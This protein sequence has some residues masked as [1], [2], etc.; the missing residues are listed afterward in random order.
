MPRNEVRTHEITFCAKVAKWSEEIFRRHPE[1]P[2]ARVEIEE[3]TARDR[4]RS[5]L[6]VYDRKGNIPLCGEVKLPGTPEGR[7]PYAHGLIGDAFE[8][9]SN[10]GAPFFF[11]WNVN[12]LVLFDSKKWHLAID[13]RQMADYNLGLALERREDVDRPEVEAQIKVFLETFY[14]EF[15]A[16]LSGAKPDWA[17]PLGAFFLRAFESHLD[18]P[19]KL[20]AAYLHRKAESDKGFDARLQ[21]WMIRDQSWA[22]IRHDP[23]EWRRLLDRAART[24]CYVFA[25]RLLFYESVRAKF[26]ELAEL[27]IP[28]AGIETAM[29]AHFQRAFQEAVEVTGDYET[30]FYPYEAAEDWVGPL[31][32]AHQEAAEAWGAVL[33]N[34]VRFDLRN[35]RTDILG[36]IFKRL[37]AP[38]ERRR[39]GQ[40]YTNEDLVDVINAFCIR[41]ANDV[42]CDPACGSGSFLVRAYHRKAFLDPHRTHEE[43]LSEIYGVD[44]ALFAAH[45][46]TLNLASRNVQ[47]VENYPR[48]R[49]GNFFE[50]IKDIRDGRPFCALPRALREPDGHREKH[51]VPFAPLDAAIGNPP[52]VRQE[53]IPKHGQKGARPMQTKE[54][55]AALVADFWPRLELSGRSDLHCYFWPAVTWR[56]KEEGWFGF[57]VSSS[58]LDVEY[59][60]ALQEWILSNFKIHAIMESHAEPWFEDAR[61]KTCAVILQRCSDEKARRGHLVKF[62]RL[63][64][65][66]AQILGQRDGEAARQ[67]AAEKLRDT[68]IRQK[69]DRSRDEFRIIV[70]KQGDLWE[71][72]V[73]AGRLFELQKQRQLAGTSYDGQSGKPPLKVR[74]MMLDETNGENEDAETDENGNGVFHGISASGYGGGKWGKYLRAP[75]LYFRIMDRFR[76]R[77]VPL[78]EIATIRFGVKSGCDA[79]FMPRDVSASFLAKYDKH[80][81][82]T[83]PFHTGCRRDE[84]ESGKAKLVLAGDGTVHAI[85]AEYLV[86][87]VHSLMNVSRPIVRAQDLDRLILLVAKPTEK[88]K[89]TYV[90]RYLRYGERHTIVSKKSQAVP[91]SKRPTC[92][93]R[94]PWYDLTYTKRGHLVWSKSQHYRHVVVYNQHGL[95]VNCNLYDVTVEDE[96][97]RPPDVVA[98]VLNSTLVAWLKIYGGRY[99]G[100]E[101]NLKTEVVDVNMLQVPDPSS[102]EPGVA[103]A[104]REAFQRLC[105]RDTRGMVEEA[106]MACRDPKKARELAEQPLALPWELQQADRR[107]L[108]LAVFEMLG[109]SDVA[110]RERLC[111]ELYREVTAHFRQIRVV[112]IK[113]QEQRSQTNDRGFRTD[114]LA[115][116]LWDALPEEDRVPLTL[117]IA[118]NADN[119]LEVTIPDG[120]P[121]LPEASD[122]FG[123]NTVFFRQGKGKA[124]SQLALPSRAHAELVRLLASR[125]IRGSIALPTSAKDATSLLARVTD[126]LAALTEQA[127]QLAGR[128]TG[129]ERRA[130]DLADLLMQ[131]LIHGKPKREGEDEQESDPSASEED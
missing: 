122:M 44:I 124:T 30:I 13:D 83:A 62:V 53:K 50:V 112:E 68:I 84:V 46:A 82:R 113:K 40:F 5:D 118:R 89:G 86:P 97:R 111:D 58:W 107:A 96:K 105:Q 80:A 36:D 100:T 42:V 39:F 25:N 77:F 61:V 90:G 24:L 47:D 120:T 110:E 128:R 56:L 101:G 98:A 54:D 12:I 64:V 71:D 8:K 131:W 33:Q 66:L 35:I 6:R 52:Y 91:V 11:T 55:I 81:W 108:D 41:R 74:E 15:A 65:P 31:V 125:N 70:K 63:N 67:A 7:N 16:I 57:L 79:F 94:E 115:A 49:R 27:R 119:G 17:Q 29:Y 93:A 32:F 114:E 102:A 85:E 99:A 51:D 4:K 106:F 26:R 95:I 76:D 38:E 117:W 20:T 121:S 18:W 116:D 69:K 59:G 60:F 123:A 73:R 37:I 3:S 104:L 109:V 28:R 21:E 9:A 88:L 43:K 72:G 78:G 19:A 87:E 92:A 1:W 34:L 23:N 129:D 75:E 22:V 127:G 126:R 45:L 2:F 10:A 14:G 48:I 130:T 103:V